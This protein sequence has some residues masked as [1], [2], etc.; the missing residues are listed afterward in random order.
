[1]TIFSFM[2]IAYLVVRISGPL[3]QYGIR[4][5][6]GP[7]E[8]ESRGNEQVSPRRVAWRYVISA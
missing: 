7:V 2:G 3:T 8:A 6:H 1:M 4:N 5:A